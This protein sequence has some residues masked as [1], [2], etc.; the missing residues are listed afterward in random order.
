MKILSTLLLF[1]GTA[2]LL[3][4]GDRVLIVV[5]NHA[6]LGETGAATGYFLSE[7]AHPWKVFTEAGHSVDFASPR[8]GY[9]PMDPKS[10]DLEDPVNREFWHTL[11]AVEGVVATQPLAA[12]DPTAYGAIFF[13]GGHGTMWDFPNSDV[14]QTKIATLYSG[15]AVVGAVCHGPAALVGVE[16]DGQPLVKGRR[17]AGFTNAEEDAVE[18]S[19]AMPFLL[20]TRLRELGAE[21][22]AAPNFSANVVVDG[23]LVT[24]QN[25][26]SATKAAEAIVELLL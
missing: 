17:I 8:G 3:F 6:E 7:V 25:P 9:A 5:T 22:V 4:A 1:L 14:V 13:A 18:L 20:E 16:I 24:G 11:D 26:A 10:F 23:R 21:F 19:D 2:S 12:V 15:G